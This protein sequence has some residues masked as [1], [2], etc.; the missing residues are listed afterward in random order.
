MHISPKR[1][2]L[3]VLFCC[4]ARPTLAAPVSEPRPALTVEASRVDRRPLRSV[5]L[6]TGTVTAWRELRIASEASG[7]AVID[8][9]VEEGASVKKGD[10]LVSLNDTVLRAQIAQQEAAI[11]EARANVATA[12]SNLERGRTL[13]G[14]KVISDQTMDERENTLATSRA[15]LAAAE[16]ALGQLRAQLAQTRIAAPAA[17]LISSRAVNIGQVVSIGT[18]LVSMVQDGR[19]EVDALVPETDLATVKAGQSVAITG[20]SGARGEGR[21]RAVAPIVESKTRLGTVHVALPADTTLKPGMFA[22]AEIAADSATAMTVPQSALVWRGG[23]AS[24]FL[25]GR[26]NVVAA[27]LV[28][29]GR[30]VEGQ[31]EITDGLTGDE[32]VVTKG[33]GFLADGDLVKPELRAASAG[34]D[35]DAKEIAR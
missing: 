19:L 8:V 34:T 4:L 1:L 3:L 33:A 10:L 9:A 18:E 25:L 28:R 32:T 31:V 12:E 29:T 27:R 14:N 2:A 11:A 15:K 20:P 6:A 24:V 30:H 16:A 22:R 21:V 35:A 17:G 7:L 26:D 5:I 23:E 13:I